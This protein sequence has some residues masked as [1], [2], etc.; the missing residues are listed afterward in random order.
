MTQEKH[1]TL[2]T[3]TLPGNATWSHILKR[4]TS[5]RLTA[6]D[7][8][9]NVAAILL[10][11]D[12]FSERLNLPDTLK[13]QHIARLTT[14][15]VL[16]SD[17]ARIL[18]SITADTVGWHDPLGGCSDA[19]MV[20]AKYGELPYQQARNAWHQNALDGFLIELA[21]Y[22]LGLRDLMMN[23]SFFSKVE[24]HDDGSM[25]FIPNNAAPGTSVEI[26]AEM[27]TLVILNSCQHPMDPS[28]DYA[29]KQVELTLSKVPAPGPDDVCRNFRPENTRGFTL[30]ERYFQ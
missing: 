17:M 10:N 24:V 19:A 9:P 11:A 21:K 6:L 14:G 5:L 30:T 20:A 26:R 12:N 3:E 22:G 27:N 25:H 13:A 18:C 15:A 7:P 4:G 16:Y 29:A 28:P 23:V 1:E 2:W 8:N